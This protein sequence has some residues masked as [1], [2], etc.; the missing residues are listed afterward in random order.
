MQRNKV[1]VGNNIDVLKTFP[2]NSIDSIVTDPPYGLGKEP[3][4]VALL[5]DWITT[6]YHEVKGKGFMGKEWDAFVPQ[7]I[8]WKECYRVLKHGGHVLS[9][10]GTR[11]YDWMVIGLRLA[12]F[13]IRDQLAWIYGSG[14]PK[15]HD[16]SKAI[17]KIY[18]RLNQFEKFAQHFN[19]QFEKSGIKRSDLYKHFSHYKNSESIIAQV[20]NWKLA[21]N[22]PSKKD[23]NILKGLIGL[24]NDFNDLIDRIEAER[25]VIGK[26]MSGI[27][28]KDEKDRHTIGASKA[29]EVDITAPSTDQAKQWQGWGTALK[30]ALEPIVMARKPLDGTVADNVL[31]HGVGGINIDGCRVFR[32]E[33]DVSSAGNRTSTFGTQ[34]TS[35]GGDGS[36]GWE[37]NSNGRFPAN[38]I[39]DGSDEVVALF[40][41]S[42][43]GGFPKNNKNGNSIFQTNNID[44]E[45][46]INI[47][48]SGSASRFFYTAKAS[49]SERNW[50]LDGFESDVTTDGRNKPI[51][52]AFNRGETQRKNIHPTVKP[53]DLMR[54]LVRLVTPKGGVCLDP[55]LGSGTTAVACKS[56]KFDYIGIELS[57]EYAD[58]AE[59][60]I[61]AEV[62]QYDIFDILEG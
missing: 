7:P 20:S 45:Q 14:F 30:P 22:V 6:G 39:H 17:D 2:D 52:N 15:S 40:P 25:E 50:G 61:K 33:N 44:R 48:D 29:I 53:I 55:F 43:G 31:K 13:E 54:Y 35:A 41:E 60:R 42:E 37:Q 24:S 12:G 59:A 9:F 62:V 5:Q 26:K 21:K 27:A 46:R 51:D 23:F 34:N 16:I 1:Y 28:N 36:G 38:V 10:A 58:I 19:E 8:F 47:N 32:D 56:E 11:T 18:P 4:A 57:Q 3:D 49:Q